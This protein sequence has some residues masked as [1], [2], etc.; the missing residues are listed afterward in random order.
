MLKIAHTADFHIGALKTM[1][2]QGYLER[3]RDMLDELKESLIEQEV[4]LLLVC[5]DIFEK[6]F[7][8]EDERA[9]FSSFLVACALAPYPKHTIVL[10]GNHDAERDHLGA[11]TS[12]Q[13]IAERFIPSLS[14][15]TD[16]TALEIVQQD[17]DW[18]ME[19]V[20]PVSDAQHLR[21]LMLPDEY[22]PHL[23]RIG[24]AVRKDAPV[25]AQDERVY[26]A[27][28]QSHMVISH[29]AAKGS[30]FETGTTGGS[31]DV[32]YAHFQNTLLW[33]LGDIHKMQQIHQTPDVWYCGTPY[34]KNFGEHLPK[35][36]LVHEFDLES[37]EIKTTFVELTRATPLMTYDMPSD[38]EAFKT[39]LEQPETVF[40]GKLVKYRYKN[41]A[42]ED[43][44]VPGNFIVPEFIPPRPGVSAEEDT[45]LQP[46]ETVFDEGF[47]LGMDMFHGIDAVIAVYCTE[48]KTLIPEVKAAA[49]ELRK[50]LQI[51]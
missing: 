43:V 14:L 44:R 24:R 2:P 26:A 16:I 33:C 27:L 11:L 15:Y 13:E 45:T 18:T 23:K 30:V 21:L 28:Q 35:G 9:L 10:P 29:Y 41:A 6:Y 32:P 50:E 34:Q 3:A 49:F 46:N 7:P 20:D 17:D 25:E 22:V 4:D 47:E 38:L 40:D 31:V 39:T 51:H 48:D 36:Y 42:F 19:K 5:G 8:S 12:I 1:Y 37:G